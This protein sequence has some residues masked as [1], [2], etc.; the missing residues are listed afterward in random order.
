MHQGGPEQWE[1]REWRE[2]DAQEVEPEH[3]EKL[4]CTQENL[5]LRDYGLPS[6]EV[7]RSS[8]GTILCNEF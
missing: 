7:F 5:A 4:Y 8:L 2:V 3:Q 6:A 1:K